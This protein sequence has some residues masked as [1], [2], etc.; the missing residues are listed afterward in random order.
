M[1]PPRPRPSRV[2]LGQRIVLKSNPSP[3]VSLFLLQKLAVT[4]GAEIHSSNLG[5]IYYNI[6]YFEY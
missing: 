6:V 2:E 4:L 1:I 3:N 5:Y